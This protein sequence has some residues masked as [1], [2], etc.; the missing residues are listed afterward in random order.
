MKGL[1]LE[2]KDEEEEEEE[3]NRMVM[4]TY[5]TVRIYNG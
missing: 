4:I 1:G 2:M 3:I 5:S